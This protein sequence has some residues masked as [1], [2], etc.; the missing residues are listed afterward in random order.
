[1]TLDVTEQQEWESLKEW[2]KEY[3]PAILIGIVVAVIIYFGWQRWA[4]MRE[5]SLEHASSH[6]EQLLDYMASN[7][8][9]NAEKAANYLIGR[10]PK[11][12]YAKLATLLLARNA[13]ATGHYDDAKQKLTWVMKTASVP[14]I[15]QVARLR[16]ARLDI[17]M[18]Q[19]AEALSLLQ[20]VEI[21][22]YR[23]PTMEVMGDAYIAENNIQQAR[24]AYQQALTLLPPSAVN[25]PFLQMKLDD[26]PA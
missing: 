20:E 4:D 22:D 24:Q 12:S 26:L 19:P 17:A 9:A 5:R 13:I 11:S 15:R 21:A 7:D 3:G 8:S 2:F 10:Y 25:R 23:A 18:K 6:Y 16:L 14:S 1:M